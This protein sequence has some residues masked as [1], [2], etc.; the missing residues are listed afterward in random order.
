MPAMRL[1]GIIIS[2]PPIGYINILLEIIFALE[3]LCGLN[4]FNFLNYCFGIIQRVFG[5]SGK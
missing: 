3:A 4:N 2:N 5:S 1:N